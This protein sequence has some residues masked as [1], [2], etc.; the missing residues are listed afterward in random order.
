[1]ARFLNCG[2]SLRALITTY[3]WETMYNIRGNDLGHS[4]NIKDWVIR[5]ELLRIKNVTIYG[6]RSTTRT[7]NKIKYFTKNNPE[8]SLK[9]AINNLQSTEIGLREVTFSM[10]A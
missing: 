8:K 7:A 4:K 1:M 5:S 3:I 6:E 2:D 9:E 10:K